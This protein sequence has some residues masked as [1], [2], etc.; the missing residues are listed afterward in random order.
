MAS[1]LNTKKQKSF[2]FEI[3]P[4]QTR[5]YDLFEFVCIG[6]KQIRGCDL[7]GFSQ[8]LGYT[9]IWVILAI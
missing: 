6:P 3:K 5:G 4:K 1:S 8:I 2:I 9:L 7:F